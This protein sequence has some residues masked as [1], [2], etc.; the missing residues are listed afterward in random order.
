M[1]V[2][3]DPPETLLAALQESRLDVAILTH[4]PQEKNVISKFILQEDLV[5]S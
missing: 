5:C 1:E 2:R 3:S 4:A